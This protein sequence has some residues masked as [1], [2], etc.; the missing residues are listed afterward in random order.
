MNILVYTLESQKVED[1]TGTGLADLLVNRIIRTP[2]D[3]RRTFL[4]D[5]L[6]MP[7]RVRMGRK[8]GY[9]V[10]GETSNWMASDE[11][12]LEMDYKVKR[13][14][15]STEIRKIVTIRLAPRVWA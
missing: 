8:M 11:I 4:D 2:L 15:F 5:P 7:R 12:H 3:P 10:E 9:P 1:F 13:E 14:R 6:W